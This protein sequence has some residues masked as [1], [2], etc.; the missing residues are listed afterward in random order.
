MLPKVMQKCRAGVCPKYL[1]GNGIEIGALHSPVPVPDGVKVR[2]V[3]R[4]AVD[5][6]MSHYS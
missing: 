5:G 1:R 4:M 3:N 6:L 2:F